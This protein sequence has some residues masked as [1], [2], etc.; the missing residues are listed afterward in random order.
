MLKGFDLNAKFG[1]VI[2]LL[3]LDWTDE[4]MPCWTH[5]IRSKWFFSYKVLL[6]IKE[7]IPCDENCGEATR[8]PRFWPSRLNPYLRPAAASASKH[9]L[10]VTVG[11]PPPTICSSL[12]NCWMT[13]VCSLYQWF[14]TMS[15]VEVKIFFQT[16]NHFDVVLDLNTIHFYFFLFSEHTCLAP[17]FMAVSPPK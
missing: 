10:M 15:I 12:L 8:W 9:S 2:V 5:V 17:W 3:G 16:P 14:F 6:F 13:H 1:A 11:R 7:Y 4:I